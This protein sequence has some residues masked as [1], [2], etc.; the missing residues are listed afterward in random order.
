[1]KTITNKT[2]TFFKTSILIL[3]LI[4]GF[5]SC[6]SDDDGDDGGSNDTEAT[7]PSD[8]LR[9]YVGT[10]TYTGT[11]G[12]IA[13]PSGAEADISGSPGDYTIS[14]SD[15]V[16]S[17]TGLNFELES[18]VFITQGSSNTVVVIDDGELTIQVQ[19][20]GENWV[21]TGEQ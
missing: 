18:G 3:A 1:M 20:G 21:F 12:T 7:I 11:E 5:T 16:P 19:I 6:G 15:G 8:E 14:F 17:I 4:V 2:K 10:L 9:G 13:V